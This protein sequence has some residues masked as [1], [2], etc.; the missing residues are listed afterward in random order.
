L[1]KFLK[2]IIKR[3]IAKNFFK[4]LGFILS[5]LTKNLKSQEIL[6]KQ[7]A[8]RSVSLA[9]FAYAVFRFILTEPLYKTTS[10]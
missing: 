8:Q 4:K 10:I 1:G 5:K 2:K 7:N 3:F 9:R 6:Q